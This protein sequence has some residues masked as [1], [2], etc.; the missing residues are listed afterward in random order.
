MLRKA[1]KNLYTNKNYGCF[2]QALFGQSC[3]ALASLELASQTSL[4]DIL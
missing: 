1:A 2:L 4:T 3:K